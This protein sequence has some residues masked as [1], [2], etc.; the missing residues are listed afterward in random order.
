MSDRTPQTRELL[1]RFARLATPRS[2]QYPQYDVAHVS[3]V[4]CN[5]MTMASMAVAQCEYETHEEEDARHFV[6][7]EL[8]WLAVHKVHALKL[9][10]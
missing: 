3:L 5:A 6:E 1:Q 4:N 8:E 7:L 2:L 10:R 9:R